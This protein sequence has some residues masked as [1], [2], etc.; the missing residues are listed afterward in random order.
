MVVMVM[1]IVILII[2]YRSVGY[3]P[4]DVFFRF[5]DHTSSQYLQLSCFVSRGE[6][7][8]CEVQVWL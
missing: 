7:H 1:V 5:G 2:A 3:P 4:L 6:H 8:G